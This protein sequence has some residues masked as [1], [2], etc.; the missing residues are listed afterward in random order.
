MPRRTVDPV[1]V[2]YTAVVP[3]TAT[4]IAPA[5][6][7]PALPAGIMEKIE[8]QIPPGHVGATGIRFRQSKQ[9]IVPWSNTVAWIIGDDIDMTFPVGIEIDTGFDIIAYNVGNY[10]HS[11]YLRFTIRQLAE[12]TGLP[13]LTLIDNS[14]LTGTG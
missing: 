1:V 4:I 2:P 8:L 12:S 10:P 13:T 9:Q 7:V 3:N 5:V 6:F 14:R 11:F